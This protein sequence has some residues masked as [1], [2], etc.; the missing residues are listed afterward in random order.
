MKFVQKLAIKYRKQTYGDDPCAHS[1]ASSS[2]TEFTAEDMDKAYEAGFN[3]LKLLVNDY[4][5]RF[6]DKKAQEE[7]AKIGEEEYETR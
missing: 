5:K 6:L 1:H 3:R 7:L 2:P 4:A